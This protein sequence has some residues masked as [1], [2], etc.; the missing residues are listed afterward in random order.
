MLNFLLSIALKDNIKNS[1]CS[2]HSSLK[3][4]TKKTFLK[5]NNVTIICVIHFY[6]KMTSLIYQLSLIN[7]SSISKIILFKSSLNKYIKILLKK[8]FLF[9]ILF[10]MIRTFVLLMLLLNMIKS[11]FKELFKKD[12]KVW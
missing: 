3:T 11:S 10:L 8:V 7:T 2:N 1:W 5:V 4:N 6:Q 12:K 9:T